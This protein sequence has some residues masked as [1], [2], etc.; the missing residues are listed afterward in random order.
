LGQTAQTPFGVEPS[1]THNFVKKHQEGAK[2][3][4]TQV[5]TELQRKSADCPWKRVHANFSGH[6]VLCAAGFNIR[7]L[8]HMIS[9]QGI[10][11]FEPAA[12]QRFGSTSY[13]RIFH[14]PIQAW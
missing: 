8:L 3:T 14:Y 4:D 7:W 6:A 1:V 5:I 2:Y 13:F 9:K 11:F 12:G 10:G